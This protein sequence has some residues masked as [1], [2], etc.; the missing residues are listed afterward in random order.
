MAR[1][2]LIAGIVLYIYVAT[3]L[4]NHALGILSLEAMEV[5]RDV[6]LALWRNAIG[7][8][9]LYGAI[10]THV[11]LVLWSLYRR[12]TLRMPPRE[13]LQI[14]FGLIIPVLLLEHVVGTRGMHQIADVNDT[15]GYVLSTLWINQPGT[16]ALQ[17]AAL[18]L[19]WTHG[20][21]GLFFW[22]RLKPWFAAAAPWLLGA[23]VLLPVLALIGYVDGGRDLARL[24]EDEAFVDQFLT[25]I[26]LPDEAAIAQAISILNWG[27]VVYGAMLGLV[28][29]GRIGRWMVQ[30]RSHMITVTYADG[31]K[32]A[33]EPGATILDASRRL[34]VPHASVCGGRGRCSTCRVH[35]SAGRE[36]LPA[37]APEETRVLM[38]V[39]ASDATRLACQ[40]RPTHD[41]SVTPLLAAD[42]TARDGHRKSAI[43]QG[44]EREVAILFADIRSFTAFSEKK[45]PYDVV[46]VLNQYFRTMGSAVENAG[47]QLDKFIGDGV[48]ALFGIEGD[49]ATGCRSALEAARRMAIGLKELNE[50]LKNDL[51]EPL[52]IGIGIHVGSV[53]VGDMGYA[54]TRSVT[55][56]GDAVNTASRLESMN[57]EYG[58]QLVVS[59]EVAERAKLDLADQRHESVAVRG[60]DE[61]L[62]VYI[63]DDAASLQTREMA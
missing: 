25:S 14:T 31:R 1:A 46:F 44:A 17:S 13:A 55:A 42:A 2:R 3:H 40:L 54:T 50:N 15:Y 19:A 39:G 38:R 4:I 62:T 22:L 9:V 11:V 53:I 8:V 60:R 32:I 16:G 45:L 36:S 59:G 61:P 27:Y 34:G 58:S 6:F 29:F 47:G 35:I 21:M 28:V 24:L 10:L 20:S 41:V 12:R 23:V 49:A 37:P 18:V 5:G 30:R 7:T 43:S 48:M 52:R 51:P 63:L 57:K 33:M 26:N 56:I